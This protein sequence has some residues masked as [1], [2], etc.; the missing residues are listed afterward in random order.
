MRI[1]IL[2]L[3][4]QG[5]VQ[6]LVTLGAALQARGHHVRVAT[7]A[8]FAPMVTGAGLEHFTL[9]GDAHALVQAAGGDLLSGHQNVLQ[10]MRALQRSLFPLLEGF[11]VDLSDPVLR[12]TEL[13]LNQ[14]PGDLF[15]ADLAE[16]LGIPHAMVAVMPM[17]RTGR[18]PMPAFPAWPARWLPGYS[19]LTYRLAEMLMWQAFRGAVNHWRTGTL[20]LKAV[21]FWGPYAAQYRAGVPNLLGFSAHVV[22]RP[23]DWGS[24]IHL[25]GW[26]F[27]DDA[28]WEPP[29]GLQRFLEA[30]PAPVFIGFGSMTVKDP[31]A[32]TALV[33]QAVRQ[34]GV[35]AILHRGWA[36]LGG[37]EMPPEIYALDYA[38]YG[39]LFPRMAGVVHHGGSGTSGYGFR[40]GLPSFIVPFIFD[41]FFWGSRAAA[42]GV[43]LRPVSI[44]ALT[45]DNLAAALV[46]LAADAALRECAA[47]LGAKLQAENGVQHAAGL[48]ERLR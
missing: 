2:V 42:L 34:A 31:S 9:R 37:P 10:S 45:A 18:W 12:D 29:A 47:A 4:S 11:T 7:F 26:W 21:G 22:E 19:A 43:G 40:S 5:D 16:Y 30:G 14:L 28:P 39:W 15:S 8:A 1:T 17:V 44:R 36:G 25:T 48:V 32:L 38:P 13:L 6:P 35:R 46:H 23:S 24:H 41:Q 20:G 3:G 27:P 33:V